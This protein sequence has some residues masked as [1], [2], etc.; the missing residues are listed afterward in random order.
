MSPLV[1]PFV[2]GMGVGALIVT[3]LAV[4][5]SNT[6]GRIR[7]PLLALAISL[8]GWMVTEAEP[9][10]T[11]LGRPY[12]LLVVAFPPAAFFW[13]FVRAVFEERPVTPW[14]LIPA[15]VLLLSGVSLF[16][17]GNAAQDPVWVVRNLFSAAL[18]LHAGFIIARGWRDDL[19]EARRRLRTIV[20]TTAVA[21]SLIEVAAAFAFRFKQV[22]PWPMIALGGLGG[23]TF[24]ALICVA[25][26]IMALQA[27]PAVFGV[28]RR[29]EAAADPRAEVADRVLLAKLDALMSGGAW[30]TEG[31]TIVAT[32][33]RL[34]TPEHRLRRLINQKLGYR[35][36]ADYLNGYRIG[37]AQRRLADPAEARATVA[38]IAFDL[39]YGSLGP[40][41]RA[42][43]AATGSTPTEWRR[44][45]LAD[46]SPILE[47]AV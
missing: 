10:W 21:Y 8:V 45:A 41:N 23:G 16:A 1:D 11:A 30:K 37:E 15:L 5:R 24:F 4:L 2:R 20:L 19:M 26:G 25:F 42:F 47:E 44:R 12:L 6:P 34:E 27:A 36:F 29:A 43:R 31:L 3:A 18:M 17:G 22:G 39:G 28:S 46:A 33:A 7:W 38:S 35:N 32:A 40:F 14:S 9:V 13:V